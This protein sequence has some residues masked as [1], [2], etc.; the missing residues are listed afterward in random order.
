MLA[1]DV[2]HVVRAKKW[3]TAGHGGGYIPNPLPRN[4]TANN[5]DRSVGG[6]LRR[7]MNGTA[8]ARKKGERGDLP[9]S[10]RNSLHLIE[11]EATGRIIFYDL[12]TI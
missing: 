8:A 6:H 10:C 9:R 2:P 5:P 7:E 1:H 12:S 4:G 3:I 11:I